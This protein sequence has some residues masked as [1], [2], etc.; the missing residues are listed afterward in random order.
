MKQRL[1][2]RILVAVGLLV[3]G[4]CL[5]FFVVRIWPQREDLVEDLRRADY[6]HLVP[7]VACLGILYWLRVRRWLLF[8]EP[9]KRARAAS[10]ASATCIGFMSNT[11]LPL[12][13]GELVRPY[14]LHRKEGIK[15]G[16]CL[17]T[18]AGLERAFDLAGLGVLMLIT[19]LML[20]GRL[21]ASG[22]GGVVRAALLGFAVM[23]AVIPSAVAW[24]AL[25]P[26]SF[27]RVG[28]TFTRLLPAHWAGM[29][30]GFLESLTVS[31]R[32]LHS[33]RG[34]SIAMI[35]SVGLWLAQGVSTYFVAT[36]LGLELGMTGAFAVVIAVAVAVALPQAPGFVG[37]YHAAAMVAAELFL[38]A[39]DQAGAL[40][41]VMW[42]VNI[43]PITLVGLG[44]LWHERLSLGRLFSVAGEIGEGPGGAEG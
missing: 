37:P 7:A 40:A 12:R 42:A 2:R 3:S 20:G 1:K 35:Q 6:R 44:F 38:V 39:R 22:G 32:F 15:F 31:M 24:M 36:A 25:S 28:R 27:L 30:G 23:A 26:R 14:V 13:L 43:A 5:A 16:T 10:V 11:F 8:L 9:I 33:W 34:V 21:P 4:G 17:A 18:A 29:A 41:I 19:A